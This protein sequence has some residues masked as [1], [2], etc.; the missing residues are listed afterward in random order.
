MSQYISFYIKSKS[1][2]FLPIAS[3]SRSNAIYEYAQDYAPTYSVVKPLT[4]N[5]ILEIINNIKIENSKYNDAI[6]NYAER[7]QLIIN[8]NNSMEDKIEA[9]DNVQSDIEE[10]NE[11]YDALQYALNFYDTLDT[12]LDEAKSSMYYTDETKQ[13]N[14]D[15]YIYYGIECCLPGEEDDE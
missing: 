13:Y 14:A 1:N 10:I 3:Y 7:K 9:L 5:I 6:K 11:I 8:M 12:I 2:E 4:Q 15:D